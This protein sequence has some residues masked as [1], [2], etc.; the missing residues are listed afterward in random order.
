MG[1]V[2][3]DGPAAALILVRDAL[4]AGLMGVLAEV[5]GTTAVFPFDGERGDVA[6][7]RLCPTVAL[8]DGSHAAARSE[9]FYEAA[10]DCACRVILFAPT[11]PWDVVTDSARDQPHVTII[12]PR[13][14][15]SLAAAVKAALDDV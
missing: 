7:R 13:A 1:M 9:A 10:R 14:G 3:E 12:V 11:R 6:V 15:E 8:V 4:G 2:S 5:T